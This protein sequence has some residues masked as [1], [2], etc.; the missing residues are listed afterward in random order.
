MKILC[1]I[2]SLTSGGAQR[3]LVELA[4]GFKENGNFVTFLTYHNF[5]FYKSIL[6]R[7]QINIVCIQES[8]YIKRLLKIRHYIRKGKYDAVLSFLEASNFMC[9]FAGL[10]IRTW[11]LVVGERN[12]N[13]L[14]LKSLKLIFYRWFHLFADYVVSNSI[15]NMKLVRKVNPILSKNKC[16]TIYN[17]IDVNHWKPKYNY[18]PRKEGKIT[19]IVPARQ[20]HQKNM[21][22]LIDAL[23]LLT[24]DE[25]RKI[26]ICWYGDKG[27]EPDQNKLNDSVLDKITKY[28]LHQLIMIFP[29]THNLKEII[30]ES[31][32]VGLFSLYEGLPNAICEGMA[33]GK[34]IICS[35]VSDMPQILSHEINLLFDPNDQ[36]AIKNTISYLADLSNDQLLQIGIKNR[37]IA[38]YLFNKSKIVEEYLKLL[39]R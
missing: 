34:T 28:D 12:A 19:I 37:N 25:K 23:I 5:P 27:Y 7:N 10:P 30:Q 4:L 6:E 26:Q 31:D 35:N 39:S 16:R 11:K 21:N 3:Q 2:D 33:C 1:V 20:C 22:G 14:V 24:E 9:E 15:S 38:E 17:I 36:L 18:L 13:P 29:A 8:N 32:V